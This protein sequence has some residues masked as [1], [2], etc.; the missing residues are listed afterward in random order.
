MSELPEVGHFGEAMLSVGVCAG[1]GETCLGSI[2]WLL[3]ELFQGD[4]V[5]IFSRI[6]TL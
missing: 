6:A 4:G 3:S 1:G 2:F 5:E